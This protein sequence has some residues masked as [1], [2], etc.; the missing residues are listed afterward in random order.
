[1][2]TTSKV[3]TPIL[4]LLAAGLALAACGGS[5]NIGTSPSPTGPQ[6][7]SNAQYGFSITYDP[8]F[9]KGTPEAG[10]G[11]GRSSVLNIAFADPKGTVVGNKYVDGI[12]VSV[13]TLTR[14]VKPTEVPKLKPEFQ[15]VV[16]SL[17]KGLTAGTVV[18]KLRLAQING[19]PGFRFAYTYTEGTTSIAAI[20]YFLVKGHTEYEVTGQA[21]QQ[22]WTKLSPKLG[23]A[24]T[25]FTVK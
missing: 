8:V 4:A 5:V 18:Q 21:S 24:V 11:A 20:T 25:S 14:D 6:T 2:R 16:G 12:L 1:M 13:Y 15:S 23:A 7:Y 17:M 9:E 10:T 19:V 22:N 3:L